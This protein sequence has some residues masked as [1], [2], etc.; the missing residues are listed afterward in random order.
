LFRAFLVA[1]A[2]SVMNATPWLISR[3]IMA[4]VSPVSSIYD[5]LRGWREV[6]MRTGAVRI[7][8]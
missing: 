8:V 3:S 4:A 1:G 2:F 5:Q 7:A 6:T